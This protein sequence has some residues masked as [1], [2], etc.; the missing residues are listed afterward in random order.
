VPEENI[1][2]GNS[3]EIMELGHVELSGLGVEVNQSVV[4]DFL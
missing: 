1:G 3:A 2:K 4:L